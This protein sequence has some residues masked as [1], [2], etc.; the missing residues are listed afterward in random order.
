MEDLLSAAE[1]VSAILRAPAGG[2]YRNW[3]KETVGALQIKHRRVLDALHELGLPL[4]TTNYD[5]LLE[6][7]TGLSPITWRDT[8]RMVDWLRGNEPGIYHCHGFWKDPD[9]VVL[10]VRSY[11]DIIRDSQAQDLFRALL[12][13]KVVL[14]VGFGA[15]LQDPNFGQLRK[16]MARSLAGVTECHY[17]LALQEEVPQVQS[18][19]DA[20]ERIQV[21]AF[22]EKYDDLAGFLHDLRPRRPPSQSPRAAHRTAARPRI[23]A[24]RPCYGR[25]DLLDRLANR[26]LENTKPV[27][28][29]G[30]PAIGKTT[31]AIAGLHDLRVAKRFSDRRYFVDCAGTRSRADLA[32]KIA[33]ELGVAHLPYPEEVVLDTFDTG[34]AVL[35]LDSAE[36]PL[37]ADREEVQDLLATLAGVEG[38]SL[39]VVLRGAELPLCV[40]WHEPIHVLPL[41]PA[42]AREAFLHATGKE[43]ANDPLLDGLLEDVGYVP[44]SVML[45]GYLAHAEPD[46]Q[47]LSGRWGTERTRLL[48]ESPEVSDE[49]QK[50]AASFEVSIGA[51]RMDDRARRLLSLLGVLPDGI[52]QEEVAEVFP[53]LGKAACATLRRA[54]LVFRNEARLRLHGLLREYVRRKY[55]P[56]AGDWRRAV[57]YYARLA[58]E[59][60]AQF[61]TKAADQAVSRF[62]ANL[63]NIESVVHEALH[64]DQAP[65]A[66]EAGAALAAFVCLTGGGSRDLVRTALGLQDSMKPEAR[67]RLLRNCADLERRHG[68]RQWAYEMYEAA[69]HFF[70]EAG[71]MGGAAECIKKIA[72]LAR[73]DNKLGEADEG[74][75]LALD[76]KGET[77]NPVV[78]A[79]CIVGL[80]DIAMARESY[81]EARSGFEEGFALYSQSENYAGMAYCRMRIGYSAIEQ[82]DFEEARTSF[83]Q[84]I[85]LACRAHDL[86]IKA[87]ALQGLGMAELECSHLE[88]A[89]DCFKKALPFFLRVDNT[90]GIGGCWRGLGDVAKGRLDTGPAWHFYVDAL[91]IYELGHHWRDVGDLHFRLASIASDDERP[92]HESKGREAYGRAQS[93]APSR[94]KTV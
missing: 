72:D 75:R 84:A 87:S 61:G 52:S 41:E 14:F 76:F 40:E 79:G 81:H 35:V 78:E 64:G 11:Q 70:E 20:D 26:V 77:E 94:H 24:R 37:G 46:L 83:Q 88:R 45:L 42:H 21:I 2:E 89:E 25:D 69:R 44:Y 91:K 90:F 67:P 51:P 56:N 17:R 53:N 30:G 33:Q 9:S 5:G 6:E 27:P 19:H 22:G 62:A 10:G 3:L 54:A 80:A 66:L 60:E 36:K 39:V 15:G 92:Y 18:E 7:A 29:L 48:S 31:L 58:V 23:P 49:F 43:H 34:S 50:M 82:K 63:G 32:L 68:N 93:L 38:L 1:K 85:K 57:E 8:S 55:P 65:L 86:L 71:N 73:E 59:D 16:W 74:Y 28:I 12:L 13:G 4:V 47:G